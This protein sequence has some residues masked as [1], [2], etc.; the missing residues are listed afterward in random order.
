VQTEQAV[1]DLT[2][3]A[4]VYDSAQF[5]KFIRARAPFAPRI[6]AAITKAATQPRATPVE[7][8]RHFGLTFE[9]RSDRGVRILPA[10]I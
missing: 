8:S 5:G 10:T 2:F 1:A 6:D 4:R 3:V 9:E 7:I